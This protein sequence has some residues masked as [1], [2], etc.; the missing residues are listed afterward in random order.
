MPLGIEVA[1]VGTCFP[2]SLRSEGSEWR[3]FLRRAV[4]ACRSGEPS[5]PQ[6]S[7]ELE[8][9]V[10]ERIRSI[11]HEWIVESGVFEIALRVHT[12]LE[13]DPHAEGFNRRLVDEVVQAVR[14]A[15]VA[16][17]AA[18]RRITLIGPPR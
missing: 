4:L 17:N 6:S 2:G 8:A 11:E 9:C 5:L 3:R 13:L 12:D 18:V 15:P 10:H 14:R 16:R 7:V 1:S